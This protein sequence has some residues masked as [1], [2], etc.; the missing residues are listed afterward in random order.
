ME[1]PERGQV[2]STLVPVDGPGGPWYLAAMIPRTAHFIWFG[3]AFP[4]VHILAMRSAAARG[5]FE[6]I[7]LHHSDDLD[8]TP[9]W[10]EAAATP[11]FS[12]RRI[13][14][15]ALFRA[16]GADGEALFG[17]YRDLEKPE[18][19][20]NML[21]AAILA[22]EGG[23][24]LDMDTITVASFEDLLTGAGDQRNDAAGR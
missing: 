21:R 16:S 23:V 20:A 19:R 2:K 5:G 4:W 11:G 15:A 24:Y 1:P 6:R 7:V 17:V 14:E 13:D 12:A 8:D 22:A 9:W 10:G 18:A 3:A